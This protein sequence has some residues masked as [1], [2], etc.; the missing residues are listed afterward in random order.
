MIRRI[1]A[2]SS[3]S[4]SASNLAQPA[5]TMTI[6]F[7]VI[8]AVIVFAIAAA[9][10]GT[11]VARLAD[12]PRPTVLK[13]DES[14]AWIADRLPFE[15]AAEISHDDVRRIL[16][17]HLDYFA[18]VGLVTDHGQ[19]LGGAAVPRRARAGRRVD[20][21]IDR[22]R[23]VAG[24]RRGLG[25][26]VAPRRRG[27]RQTD[28][29]LAR[30]WCNRTARRARRMTQY[31]APRER[32]W[33][34]SVVAVHLGPW[35]WLAASRPLVQLANPCQ[36]T[37]IETRRDQSRSAPKRRFDGSPEIRIA[38]GEGL[39]SP[40]CTLWA[41]SPRMDVGGSTDP[42]RTQPVPRRQ[43]PPGRLR[44]RRGRATEP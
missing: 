24:P 6:V 36:T 3:R 23:R 29:V 21:R 10:V 16:D 37:A 42:I 19:E 30:N 28:G 5:A 12:A 17:W 25:T 33:S 32:R 8:A 34:K 18:D 7:V 39:P 43:A 4:A 40:A 20:R 11:V 44:P 38:A 35:R 9:T 31:W 26:H 22:L 1:T 13:V 2:S 14:V 27:A 41:Q 15:I